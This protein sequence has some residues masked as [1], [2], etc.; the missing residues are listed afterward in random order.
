[1]KNSLRIEHQREQGYFVREEDM[2]E[3]RQ[4]QR[5]YSRIVPPARNESNILH[6]YD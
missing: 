4:V 5:Y 1:M 2:E 3:V 6:L